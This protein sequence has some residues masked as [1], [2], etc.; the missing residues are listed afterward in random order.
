MYKGTGF[1]YGNSYISSLQ[2]T[3]PTHREFL[4]CSLNSAPPHPSHTFLS[5]C[6]LRHMHPRQRQEFSSSFI[7]NKYRTMYLIMQN[8]NS[9]A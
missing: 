8:T 7:N 9:L 1:S 5:L 4:H 3:E 6:S 2:R